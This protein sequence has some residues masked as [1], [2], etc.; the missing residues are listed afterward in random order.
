[1]L[2][3][4]PLTD[5]VSS[6]QARTG[7]LWIRRVLV[8]PR[9]GT[10]KRGTAGLSPLSLRPAP[11][12]LRVG[13]SRLGVR[14]VQLRLRTLRTAQRGRSARLEGVPSQRPHMTCRLALSRVH[15]RPVRQALYNLSL[16]LPGMP[17]PL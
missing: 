4:P 16:S 7:E 1:M 6:K 13:G 17:L 2:D 11:S 12:P 14:R 10:V 3:G 15:I 9:W 8:E 5:M